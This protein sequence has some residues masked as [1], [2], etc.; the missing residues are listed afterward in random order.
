MPK[1]ERTILAKRGTLVA[2]EPCGPHILLMDGLFGFRS[3]PPL[4]VAAIS[5]G[6]G[7]QLCFSSFYFENKPM[8]HP[9]ATLG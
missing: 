2:E 7:M 9:R 6:I 8:P 1:L 3:S 4:A 5:C